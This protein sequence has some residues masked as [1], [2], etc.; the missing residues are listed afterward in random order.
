MGALHRQIT[1]AGVPSGQVVVG[2]TSYGRSFAVAEPGCYGPQCQFTGSRLT[3][4]AKKGECTDTAGYLSDAE[5]Y[6]IINGKS[7][8]L[9][10]RDINSS[11]V[12]KNYVD[13]SSNSDILVY[14]DTEWVAYMSPGTRKGRINM[15]KG[16]NMGGSV[17]WATDLE[18]YLDPPEGVSDW[19]DFKRTIKSGGDP[20][21]RAGDRNG[22]WT[23]LTCD[24]PYMV[25]I[26]DYTPQER[27]GGLDATDAWN[28]IVTDWK[29]YRDGP[30][31]TSKLEFTAFVSYLIG[32]PPK[33][34]CGDIL[35]GTCKDTWSCDMFHDDRKTGPAATFIWNSLAA[36]STVRGPF[37]IF[38][39]Q[40]VFFH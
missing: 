34:D 12:T 8:D 11:R 35:S 36:I 22:N 26:P 25:E 24:D 21:R 32:G 29:K 38:L 20:V 7:G 10:R 39:Y 14:D 23:E 37:P 1:K 28:D 33:S 13:T 16:M 31:S 6:D 18:E 15:Y 3:S 9:T 4:N 30:E 27:W 17:N 2:V 40:S 5:I 19:S